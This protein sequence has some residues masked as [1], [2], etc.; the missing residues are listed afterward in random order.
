MRVL[1]VSVMACLLVGTTGYSSEAR[2]AFG[3]GADA[4]TGVCRTQAAAEKWAQAESDYTFDWDL[5]K[6]MR[7]EQRQT[8]EGECRLESAFAH[9]GHKI[10]ARR[11]SNYTNQEVVV[12]QY[13]DTTFAIMAEF[14]SDDS[15]NLVSVCSNEDAA[16]A[17][18]LAYAKTNYKKG[19]APDV[20]KLSKNQCKAITPPI[21]GDEYKMILRSTQSTPCG[22]FK[23]GEMIFK[24]KM[25]FAIM[26]TRFSNSK[27][28]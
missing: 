2:D 8:D 7:A 3:H 15:D 10:V 17:V 5:G 26:G 13:D 14:T 12:A 11:K 28:C 6:S 24:G 22:I 4:A 19:T 21:Y 20:A 1:I 23:V 25:V 9:A 18:G 27:T 16:E